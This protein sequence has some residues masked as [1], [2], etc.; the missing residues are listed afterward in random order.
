MQ[1]TNETI[2]A[3]LDG[4]NQQCLVD[5]MIMTNMDGNANT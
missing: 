4:L 1:M 5:K 2:E 3:Q